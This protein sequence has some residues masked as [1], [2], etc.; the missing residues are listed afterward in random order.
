MT[1]LEARFVELQQQFNTHIKK[2]ISAMAE[3]LFHDNRVFEFV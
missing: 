3:T 2:Q 1:I